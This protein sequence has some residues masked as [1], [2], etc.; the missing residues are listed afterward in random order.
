MTWCFVLELLDHSRLNAHYPPSALLPLPGP[1]LGWSRWRRFGG[2][3]PAQGASDGGVAGHIAAPLPRSYSGRNQRAYRSDKDK[4][5]AERFRPSAWAARWRYAAR[6]VVLGVA[7]CSGLYSCSQLSC[8]ASSQLGQPVGC[9]GQW[10]PLPAMHSIGA[11]GLPPT[12]VA[13]VSAVPAH[14]PHAPHL[15]SSTTVGEKRKREQHVGVPAV[16][17]TTA[18]TAQAVHAAEA[19]PSMSN[20]AMKRTHTPAICTDCG[21]KHASFGTKDDRK[22]RWCGTCAKTNGHEDAV[23]VSAKMCEDCGAKMASFGTDDDHKKRWCS[24]CAK[25]KQNGGAQYLGKR[26]MCED[27]NKKRAAWGDGTSKK[28]RWCGSCVKANGHRGATIVGVKLCEDCNDKQA[29]FGVE[30]DKV[31]QLEA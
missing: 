26:Y 25:N 17:A 16:V 18:A 8:Q 20:S 9:W 28:R 15:G 23:N 22:R 7:V 24:A 30:P 6:C 31:C 19:V 27:C 4:G 11:M 2:T 13:V 1:C 21:V 5:R 14:V 12:M 10:A 3:G 29:T